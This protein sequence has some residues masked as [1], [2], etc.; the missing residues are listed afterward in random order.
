[1]CVYVCVCLCV[2][3]CVSKYVCECVCM[4]ACVC[5][6]E[7]VCVCVVFFFFLCVCVCVCVLHLLASKRIM[8]CRRLLER[9]DGCT[10]FCCCLVQ[11]Q[12]QRRVFVCLFFP[13]RIHQS[14]C[15]CIFGW[16]LQVQQL[17]LSEQQGQG[18]EFS[19]FQLILLSEHQTYGVDRIRL[20]LNFTQLKIAYDT[21]FC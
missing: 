14:S 9:F 21:C 20:R 12:R 18:G 2:Y 7:C 16:C 8:E 6:F 5:V 10:F 11:K 13:Q 17:K 15:N 1:M 4:C 3:L 19:H